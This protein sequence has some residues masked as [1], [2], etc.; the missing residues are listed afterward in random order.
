MKNKNS[1]VQQ[2]FS[3][4]KQKN[5]QAY[6]KKSKENQVKKI[7]ATTTKIFKIFYKSLFIGLLRALLKT[8][9]RAF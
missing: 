7:F 3:I 4:K 6:T 1:H 5:I 2:N 9:L 8:F